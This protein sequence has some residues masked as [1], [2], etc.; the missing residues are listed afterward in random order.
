MTTDPLL[1][2]FRR[3]HSAIVSILNRSRPLFGKSSDEA[4]AAL[5]E[6]RAQ[7][8]AGMQ[9]FQVFKHRRIFDPIIQGGGPNQTIAGHLKADCTALGNEYDHFRR[10]WTEAEMR[11]QWP[12]YR[13]SA[14]VM[15]TEIRK[16]LADQDDVV[17][18]L[19]TKASSAGL[20]N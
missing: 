8:A 3:H 6:H 7:L 4:L 19:E 11:A 14:L 12:K 15:I 20:S 10:E 13:L 17:R 2:E 9:N 18:S 16:R 1:A 5:L